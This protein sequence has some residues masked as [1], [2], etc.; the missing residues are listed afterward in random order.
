MGP[1]GIRIL[2]GV[3]HLNVYS[4]IKKLLYPI[5]SMYGIFTYIYHKSQLNVGI[6]T[7]YM[8]PMGIRSVQ[9]APISKDSPFLNFYHRNLRAVRATLMMSFS[10]ILR[11]QRFDKQSATKRPRKATKSLVVGMV[12]QHFW[13]VLT[14]PLKNRQIKSISLKLSFGK[15]ATK[16]FENHLTYLHFHP[17]PPTNWLSTSHQGE[18][19]QWKTRRLS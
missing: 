11:P 12:P 8:D 16:I 5:R 6:Y 3:S 4:K 9:S 15:D 1:G 19:F 10:A 13:L 17:K 2:G 18:V 7:I 14:T